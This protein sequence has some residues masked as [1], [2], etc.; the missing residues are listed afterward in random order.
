[1]TRSGEFRPGSFAVLRLATAPVAAAAPTRAAP[2]PATATAGE[3]LAYLREL[4]ADPKLFEAIEV[5]SSSL[6]RT[7]DK[8]LAEDS[9]G[10]TKPERAK[11]ERAVLAVTR[12]LLRMSGRPTPFGLLAGVAPV[13]FDGTAKVRIGSAHTR[14]VAPDS[15][16]LHTAQRQQLPDRVVAN[17]LAE[18]RGDRL[19]LHYLR[20]LTDEEPGR[21]LSVANTPVVQLLREAAHRPIEYAVLRDRL[22]QAHPEAS[23]ADADELLGQLLDREILLAEYAQVPEVG[24][25]Y[26][27]EGGRES[28]RAATAAAYGIVETA[29]PPLQVDLRLDADVRLPQSVADEAAR[30]AEVLWRLSPQGGGLPRLLEYH[31]EFLDRYGTDRV[32]PV[33]ELLDPHLGLGPPA[34]YRVPRGERPGADEPNNVYPA[35]RDQT[36]AAMLGPS[37]LVLDDALVDRLA[38]E[39]DDTAPDSLDLCAQLLADSA[40]AVERGEFLLAATS[41]S[42]TAGA[43]IGRFASMLGLEEQLGEL[44]TAGSGPLAVQLDFQPYEPRSGNVLRVPRLLPHLLSVGTFADPAD[45]GVLDVRDVAVGTT[46]D[47]LYLTSPKVDRELR[48]IRPNMLNIVTGV[49]NAARFLAA[50]GL[51]GR[52][53]WTPWQWGRLEVL[54]RLPRVRSGRT[55]LAPALWRTDPALGSGKLDTCEWNDLL[56]RWR[57]QLEVPDVVRVSIFDHHLDLDLRVP[58][59]RRLLRDQLRKQPE[60]VVSETPAAYG[61]GLGSGSGS[62]SGFGLGVTAGHANELVIPLVST[63]EQEAVQPNPSWRTANAPRIRHFPGGEWLYT[64]VYAMSDLHDGLLSGQVSRLVERMGA[65][66]WFFLRYRDPD[67]HLRLRFHAG[68]QAVLHDWAREAAAAGL[69]RTMVLDEYEPETVRYGG[70][71]V[72]QAAEELFCADSRAVIEQLKLRTQGKLDLPI[73]SLVALNH[74]DLLTSFGDLEQWFVDTYPIDLSNLVPQATRAEFSRLL[75]D[76]QPLDCWQQRRVAAARYGEAVRSNPQAVMSVLHMHA[77]RLLGM[78][79]AAE[80]RAYGVLRAGL[81]RRLDQRRH[82]R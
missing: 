14:S 23:V 50:V 24:R 63:A 31:E 46:G 56:D 35:T 36:L 37:E 33:L 49:P 19:V 77:N 29:K 79:R 53:H 81:R 18:V 54:P 17:N 72:L 65:E 39:S 43:M 78:D 51:V 28:W 13:Q 61:A 15:G 5:S 68:D 21:Q 34:G 62:G 76:F 26:A 52:R 10:T 16:W 20:K 75:A 41:G 22:L 47:R 69:I 2:D 9:P 8:L 60:S 45:P 7:L 12:Y 82:G 42:V 74:L 57:D 71:E 55:I 40:E 64:K 1:M 30:A 11:L 38:G 80:D 73:E 66:R 48:V 27:L 25:E 67:A 70:P 44:L 6:A 3:L 32:V 4:L 59:H 58:M